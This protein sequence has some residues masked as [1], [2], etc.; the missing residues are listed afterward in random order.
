MD[1]WRGTWIGKEK[2]FDNSFE[3]VVEYYVS[4]NGKDRVA[5]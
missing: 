1:P 4:K 2:A 3:T 5:G